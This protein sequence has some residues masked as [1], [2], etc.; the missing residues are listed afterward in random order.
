MTRN[1][2]PDVFG[3]ALRLQ[4]LGLSIIPIGANKRPAIAKWKP[5]QT[6]VAAESQI[7]DWF[8]RR[9]DLGI[10]IV[11]GPVSGDLVARDFDRLD[12]YERWALVYPPLAYRLPTVETAR[13]RHVYFRADCHTA[14]LNDGELRGEGSY[15]V[16]PPSVHPSG[17]RYR[18]TVPLKSL[19]AVPW[20]TPDEAGFGTA[21]PSPSNATDRTDSTESILSDLW[22]SARSVLSVAT[23]ILAGTLPARFGTRRRRLFELARRVRAAPQLEGVPLATLRPLVA[24]WHRLALPTIRTKPFDE[25]WADFV[26]AFQNPAV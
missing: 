14:T 2:S 6:S 19:E 21:P 17:C 5:F 4:S 18:W 20:L 13:G 12:A 3:E 15:V 25:T 9:D 16:A 1:P 10:G 22:L 7:H 24:E 23:D 26:E 11:L 8:D